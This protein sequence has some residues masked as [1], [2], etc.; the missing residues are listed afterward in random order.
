MERVDQGAGGAQRV[1]RV[2][3]GLHRRAE[4]G[5]DAVAEELV[6]DESAVADG[7]LE[8]RLIGPRPLV[9]FGDRSLIKLI[10]INAL[11]NAIESTISAAPSDSEPLVMSWGDTDVDTWVTILDRGIG[12]P[13]AFDRAFAIG[14]TTKSKQGHQGMGLAIAKQAADSID[15]TVDLRPRDE[16]G[17]AFDVRWPHRAGQA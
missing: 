17:A 16:G 4:S 6:E 8:I 3:V 15:G 10:L 12:L 13:L 14:E 9:V 7:A 5:H 2:G 1:G 11:R